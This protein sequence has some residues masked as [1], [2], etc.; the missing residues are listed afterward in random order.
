MLSRAKSKLLGSDG[1][2]QTLATLCPSPLDHEPAVFGGHANEEA[3]GSLSGDIGGLE[4][5]F[6]LYLLLKRK[7]GM[8]FKGKCRN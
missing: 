1:C 6:H 7:Y 8:S 5:S 4:C 3:V 2:S